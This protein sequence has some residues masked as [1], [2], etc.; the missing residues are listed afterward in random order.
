[1]SYRGIDVSDFQKNLNWNNLN[2]KICIIKATEGTYYTNP[3]LKSQYAKA[4]SRGMLVGFYAFLSSGDA[5][6]QAKYFLNAISG[7]QSDTKYICDAETNP[8]GVSARVRA[9]A[10]YLTSQGKEP[11]LYTGLSFYNTEITSV[12]K[13][14][15]VWLAK[16]GGFRPNIPSI[17][18]QYCGT[19][20]DLNIFD[21]EFLLST[22]NVSA[23]KVTVPTDTYRV[24]MSWDNEKSEIACVNDLYEAKDVANKNS[25]YYVYNSKGQCL[26][27]LAKPVVI[28]S[29]TTATTV[30]ANLKAIQVKLNKLGFKGADN[31]TLTEDGLTGNN[32]TFSLK[33]AQHWMKISESG[34]ADSVTIAGI[35]SILAKPLLKVGSTGIPV[36]FVQ[37]KLGTSHDGSFQRNTEIS[38]IAYQKKCGIAADGIL[39]NASWGK[40]IG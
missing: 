12:C 26:Y 29:T 27:T 3:S 10:D 34:I 39:G 4:K 21:E 20:L 32:T 2:A 8:V 6:S 1:M 37:N 17:A 40:L 16:Y 14:I 38:V 11:C 19:G 31:K 13:G 28:T 5:V 23:I 36:L 24:R 30:D 25:G 9:F 7:L 35:N 33:S 18:W 15:P 22:T